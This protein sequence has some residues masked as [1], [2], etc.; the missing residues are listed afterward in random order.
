[1]RLYYWS[2]SS[3]PSSNANTIN[4]FYM[5]DAF[6]RKIEIEL[7]L[8]SN[9]DIKSYDR[10]FKGKFKFK[11]NS[12]GSYNFRS[13]I[14]NFFKFLF[15]SNFNFSSDLI[16]TRS[17]YIYFISWL[18]NL[19]VFY[20]IHNTQRT[21]LHKLLFSLAKNNS[22]SILIFITRNLSINYH[23]N[24]DYLI[25]P[26]GSIIN[27]DNFSL[28]NKRNYILSN[29]S[30]L[31]ICYVGSDHPGKGVDRVCM[32]AKLL[33]EFDFEIVGVERGKYS[34][35]SNCNVRGRLSNANS[36]EIMANCHIFLLP[37]YNN[38]YI[39]SERDIGE[40]TSPL[41]LFEYFSSYGCVLATRLKILEE[42]LN[43]R[44]SVLIE[45]SNFVVDAA[46][47]IIELNDN[48]DYLINIADAS[49]EELKNNY[50]WDIRAEKIYEK[51][52]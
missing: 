6:S 20:E 7:F 13:L 50:T 33:P 12:L 4:V 36:L 18:F 38:I 28:L 5:C 47:M 1:M 26:S 42:I 22:N 41:K 9:G 32:L 40:F 3:F 14:Y 43:D 27:I 2:N 11:I 48:R 37:N 44:N 17:I 25:L 35:T 24:C 21:V 49:F 15:F 39:N 34:W 30:R 31:K 19:K 23:F 52:H 10:D 46:N 8:F 51:F 45:E 16:F 29:D